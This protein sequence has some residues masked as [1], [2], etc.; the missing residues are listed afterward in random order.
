MLLM[1]LSFFR[2]CFFPFRRDGFELRAAGFLFLFG[3]F[4]VAYYAIKWLIS[5]SESEEEKN[6]K[7]RNKALDSDTR[8]KVYNEIANKQ[9]EIREQISD[10]IYA[11]LSAG[12]LNDYF[13]RLSENYVNN[14]VDKLIHS[15]TIP[16]E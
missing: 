4:S 2:G 5:A 15:V 7:M 6:E 13:T 8:Q 16:I 1:G 14:Y 10:S 9:D 11:R 12:N 3:L